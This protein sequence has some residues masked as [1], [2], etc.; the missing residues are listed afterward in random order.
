[1]ELAVASYHSLSAVAVRIVD[2][3]AAEEVDRTLDESYIV[4]AEGM[5]S[6]ED[7]D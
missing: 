3:A 5:R 6:A 7:T 1:M 2:T 4:L